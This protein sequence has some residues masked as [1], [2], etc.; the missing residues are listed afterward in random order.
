[1]VAIRKTLKGSAN[2]KLKDGLLK[3]VIRS[4]LCK[5]PRTMGLWIFLVGT[6][7]FQILSST[8]ILNNNDNRSITNASNSELSACL[9]VMDDNHFLVEWLAYHYHS[10]NLRKLVLAIDPKSQT[11]PL[12]ILGRWKDKMDITIW[13]NDDD[14]IA[15]KDFESTKKDIARTFKETSPTLIEHRARQ[16]IFYTQC[17]RT[18]KQDSMQSSSSSQWTMLV[19]VDEFVKVNYQDTQVNWHPTTTQG[20]A[21]RCRALQRQRRVR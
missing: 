14:Y 16:R 15:S 4:L 8:R 18:I 5:S 7:Y 13:R 19:D 21:L 3:C 20:L 1:M 9:L 17:L 2:S 11:M 12:E 6:V 10:A